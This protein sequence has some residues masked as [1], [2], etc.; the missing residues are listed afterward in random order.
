MAGLKIAILN[1]P[2]ESTENENVNE[3][4][5]EKENRSHGEEQD[6]WDLWGTAEKKK[7]KIATMLKNWNNVNNGESGLYISAL[8]TQSR[9]L[10]NYLKS[11]PPSLTIQLARTSFSNN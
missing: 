4:E 1:P 6:G 5:K 8:S 10:A 7:K 3:K 2:R 9:K 11:R